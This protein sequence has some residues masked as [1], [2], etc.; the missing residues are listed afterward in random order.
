MLEAAYYILYSII[1]IPHGFIYS[2][3]RIGRSRWTLAGSTPPKYYYISLGLGVFILRYFI[4][5]FKIFFMLQRTKGFSPL[6]KK[7]K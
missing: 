6:N 5:F 1:C 2:G 7:L 4:L 3:V